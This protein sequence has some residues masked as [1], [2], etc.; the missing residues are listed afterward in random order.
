MKDMKQVKW[1]FNSE[2]KTKRAVLKINED[3]KRKR[4]EYL[5]RKP[6]K[7]ITDSKERKKK[8]VNLNFLF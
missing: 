7:S 5:K 6:K 4:E 2:V 8:Y 3:Y 1:S